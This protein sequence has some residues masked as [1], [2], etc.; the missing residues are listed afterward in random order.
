MNTQTHLKIGN[1]LGA[2]RA[3]VDSEMLERAFLETSDYRAL[4]DTNQFNFIVGR[5]GTGKTALFL[6]LSKHL[7]E[8]TKIFSHT[9]KPEEYDVLAFSNVFKRLGLEHYNLIRPAA[10]V[11][12]RTAMLMSVAES[13]CRYWK[14]RERTENRWLADY[15]EANAS[16]LRRNELQRCKEMLDHT[17]AVG[18]TPEEIPG[19]IAS[20]YQLS[21]LENEIRRGLGSVGAKAVFLVDGLDEGWEPTDRSTAV[22]GGLAA[23]VADFGDR[24]ILIQ[25]KL[26]I[27]DNIFRLLAQADNDFS[28]HIEGSTLRLDW[29]Q[30]SLLNL[31]VSRLRIVLDLATENNIRVWNRFAYRELKDRRGFQRCLQHTLYRPRDVLVLLNRAA[32]RAAREGRNEIVEDDIEDTS[33]QISLDRLNDLLKEYEGYFQGSASLRTPFRALR[34]SKRRVRRNRRSIVLSRTKPMVPPRPAMS[35]YSALVPNSWMHFTAWDL[36]AKKILRQVHFFFV[37][38]V[39]CPAFQTR[40]RTSE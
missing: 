8:N 40:P 6:H 17:S 24:N 1:L 34:R 33:R 35:Q 32:V 31:V 20:D 21:M 22:L 5:R 19:R 23:A 4:K 29:S 3:E 7:S 26:F 15:L 12:W 10:R 36:W 27:R 2:A 39:P 30:D 16:L 13:L 11:L 18:S 37:T 38:T 25:G 28:R 14:Y 9:L